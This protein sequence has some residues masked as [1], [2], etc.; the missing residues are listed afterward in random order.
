[1]R[2]LL[3]LPIFLAAGCGGEGGAPGNE[4]ANRAAAPPARGPVQTATLTGLYESAGPSPSQLCITEQGRAARFGLVTR[5][6][7]G[8][9]LRF[10]GQAEHGA[11]RVLVLHQED[12]LGAPRRSVH[13]V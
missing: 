2:K 9:A 12:G 8:V 5:L 6:D 11:Q 4:T 13:R 3:L 10:Q 7:D 1:M